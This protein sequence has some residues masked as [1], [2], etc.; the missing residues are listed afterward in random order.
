MFKA[1]GVKIHKTADVSSKAK[2]GKGTEI[3]NDV[4]IRKNSKIGRNC[5]IH[6]GVYIDEDVVVGNN[7]KIQVNASLFKGV[8]LEDDV[9]VGP[10]VC[11]T[12]DKFPKAVGD[13][14]LLKTLVKKGAAI[15]ANSTILP[16]ITIGEWSLVGAGSVVTKDVPKKT[17]VVGNPAK[18][19]GTVGKTYNKLARI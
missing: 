12:N 3:W 5:I 14:K 4:K 18:I 19:I 15:G 2:I 17:I 1:R 10:H 7:V 9:F 8:I 16:G 6:K 11:F 13:W